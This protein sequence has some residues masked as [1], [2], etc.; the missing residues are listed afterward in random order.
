MR[1]LVKKAFVLYGSVFPAG[2]LELTPP[3][4]QS[5]IKNGLAESAEPK[6]ET[7]HAAKRKKEEAVAEYSAPVKVDRE[8]GE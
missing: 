1:V 3:M 6:P 7:P 4:A 8:E 5:L 2:Y